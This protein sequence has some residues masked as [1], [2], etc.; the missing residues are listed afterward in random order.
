[1][2]KL[3]WLA[4]VILSLAAGRPAAGRSVAAAEPAMPQVLTG[5]RP[6]AVADADAAP[7]PAACEAAADAAEQGFGLPAGLL[8]AIGIVESGRWQ[9]ALNRSAPWPYAIDVGGYDL[10][11]DDLPQ[12]VGKVASL[13]QEGFESIDVGCFQIN[14]LYHPDAF[15]SL[16]EAFDPA[17]NAAY[18][19]RFLLDLH[20]RSGS[21]EQAVADYHSAVPELGEPYRLRVYAV[22]RGAPPD[23]LA[24]GQGAHARLSVAPAAPRVWAGWQAVDDYRFVRVASGGGSQGAGRM[25]IRVFSPRGDDMADPPA[26]LQTAN[27]L[28]APRGA[29]PAIRM[30]SLTRMTRHRLPMV[31]GPPG[32]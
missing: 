32:G 21:W 31:Y 3:F 28:A 22:W 7:S 17:A 8:R 29:V 18:A 4:V 1:M 25:S 14:L 26:L 12:A 15:A 16:E 5:E 6:H 24:A 23:D 10:F 19:A 30:V 20:A 2:P 9:P 13:R 27:A 11:M